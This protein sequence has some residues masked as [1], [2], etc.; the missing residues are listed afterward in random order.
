MPDQTLFSNPTIINRSSESMREVPD[1]SVTL[2]VTS[3]P[4]WNAIDYDGYAEGKR[5][6]KYAFRT[7]AYGK[8]F[9]PDDY[10]GYLALMQRIFR[11]VYRVTRPGGCC[12]IVVA[13]IQHE[14]RCYPIPF[15][16]TTRMQAIGWVVYHTLVWN[17]CRSVM[18]RGGTFI[19]LGTPGSFHPNVYTEHILVFRKP[20]PRLFN[21]KQTARDRLPI[22]TLVKLDVVKDIWHIGTVGPRTIEHPC[23]FPAEVP[24]RLIL[25]Y[26][27]TGD[28]VLDPFCG[29]GQTGAVANALERRFVGYE[30]E[31]P[32]AEYARTRVR[33]PP[34]LRRRQ[35]IARY[36]HL[37]D[38]PFALIGN[39]DPAKETPGRDAA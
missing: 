6:S 9:K 10:E 24:H 16:L 37:E 3:P 35:L 19:R 17:K 7:R 5:S 8:G 33:Q 18:D 30:I 39:A 11:E 25:L 23:P 4:Y 28:L 29:S 12:A 31:T 36:Q 14:G 13:S 26:S 32:F 20:G 22:S 2:T 1:D 34:N 38:D 27:S 15:D 21:A